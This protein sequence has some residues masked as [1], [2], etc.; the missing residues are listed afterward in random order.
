MKKH[1]KRLLVVG[2]IL[3]VA[4]A[5]WTVLVQRVDVQAIGPKGTE[6]GFATL[7]GWFHK[8]TGAH[9]SIYVITDWLGLVPIFVCVILVSFLAQK[10]IS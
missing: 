2:S 6:V 8:W 10:T 4:F 3:V 7:N 1:G 5:I 9:M